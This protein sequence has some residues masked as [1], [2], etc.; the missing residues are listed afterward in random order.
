VNANEFAKLKR[1]DR[2]LYERIMKGIVLWESG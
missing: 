2:P 1:E